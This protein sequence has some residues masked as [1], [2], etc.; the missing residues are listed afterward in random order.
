MLMFL[1]TIIN[2]FGPID[3]I[4]LEFFNVKVVLR[5]NIPQFD[6]MLLDLLK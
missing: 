6:W 5:G 3:F 1:Y 2:T 4:Q